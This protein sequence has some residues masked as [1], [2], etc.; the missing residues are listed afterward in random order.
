MKGTDTTWNCLIDRGDSNIRICTMVFNMHTMP[1]KK[2]VSNVI[3]HTCKPVY[4]ATIIL[5]NII[6]LSIFNPNNITA[7]NHSY[8]FLDRADN[9]VSS[10]AAPVTVSAFIPDPFAVGLGVVTGCDV[11]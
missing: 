11:D 5:Y 1:W 6:T 8:F 9:V 2:I 7:I 3:L 4:I 10:D